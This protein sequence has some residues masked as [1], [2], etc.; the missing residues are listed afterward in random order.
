MRRQVRVRFAPSP[1]G[2]LHIGSARTALFNYL[3]AKKNKGTLIL[4]IE[5]TD[6][7]RSQ[8]VFEKDIKANLKWL[9]LKWDEEYYQSKRTTLYKKHLQQLLKKDLAY[10]QAGAVYFR[11]PTTGKIVVN[12]IIR[13][14][15]EFDAKDVDDFVIQKSDGGFVFHFVNVVDDW[16]MKITHVI[17]GED[18]LSNTPKHILLFQALNAPIPEYAHIPLILNEDRSKMSKRTGD[19]NFADY[20][21]KGY[22]PEALI[23]FL[24]QLGWSDPKGR[25]FFSLKEL[26]TAF[27]LSR[28][29]KAGAVFDL[30][31]LNHISHHYLA[32]LS[33]AAYYKIAKPYIPFKGTEAYHK[34]VLSLLQDRAE[35]LAQLTELMSYFYKTSDYDKNLLVFKKSSPEQTIT[36]LNSAIRVL[37]KLSDKSWTKKKLQQ[38]LDTT[39]A[40]DS[41]MPGDIFWPVRVALSGLSGSPSP[42]ELLDVLGKEESIKRLELALKKLD[43]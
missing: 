21:A 24:V 14:K 33:P 4:R 38:V 37:S 35:Y 8:K 19:V 25:E 17:R 23:N 40:V 3:F 31:Y 27:D 41:L 5:D 42:V 28:V 32:A 10:K 34:K 13:G 1:T 43:G 39:A 22:L 7:E 30:K 18:H 9:G 2:A 36:G 6:K 12:D 15:V 29:Q 20:V 16:D 26:I 11:T